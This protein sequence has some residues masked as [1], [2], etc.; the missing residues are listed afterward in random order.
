MESN[1]LV[2]G[3]GGIGSRHFESLI[4][5]GPTAQIEVRDFQENLNLVME[6]YKSQ[7][8]D[9]GTDKID[10]I[11]TKSPFMRKRYNF[12]II[13]TGASERFKVLE[14]LLKMAQVDNLILEKPLAN[15]F[16]GISEISRLISI[17]SDVRLNLPRETMFFYKN[18]KKVLFKNEKQ[19]MTNSALVKGSNWG[20]LSNFLHFV[21]LFEFLAG[22]KISKIRDFEIFEVYETKRLGF[23]DVYGRM[24]L[25]D[26]Y[27]NQLVLMDSKDNGHLEISIKVNG[28]EIQVFENQGFAKNTKG[29]IVHGKIEYQSKLTYSY[30]DIPSNRIVADLPAASEYLELNQSLIEKLEVMNFHNELG[31]YKFT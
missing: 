18:I 27:G 2:I 22:V 29:E 16:K 14:N 15:S 5:N 8:K 21:R 31:V 4:T 26:S 19:E 17:S 25:I 10:F 23:Y 13:A 3:I 20:L 1:I 24:C 6:N 9:Y 12:A 7:I 11:N 30:L 28:D